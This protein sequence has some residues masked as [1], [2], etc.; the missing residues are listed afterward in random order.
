MARRIILESDQSIF[1]LNSQAGFNQN[2][3]KTAIREGLEISRDFVDDDGNQ[4]DTFGQGKE[5]T[6]RLRIRALKKPMTNVAVVDL[7]PGGFEVVRSSVPRTAFNWRADYVD[8][9]EDRVIFYGAFD[10]SIKELEYKVKLTAAGNFVAPPAF[11]E[12][13]YDRSIKASTAAARFEVTPS[14]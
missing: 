13:M 4:L 8:I 1:Y 6:V 9:R 7:L 11:A 3:P 5:I 14:H 12:S 10:T 2:L